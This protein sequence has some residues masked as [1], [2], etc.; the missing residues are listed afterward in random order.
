[1]TAELRRSLRLTDGVAMIVGII[2]GAGIFRTP[3]VVAA[4]LGR[5][6]L[7]FVAWVLGGV[8]ALAGA[9]IFAE[10]G[11]RHP[12]A[13]GKYVYVREAFGPRAGFVVGIVEVGI[14][15]AVIAALAVSAGEYA[16]RLVGWG[17][18]AGRLAAVGAVVL[19]TAINLAG[20]T[21]G[22]VLQNVVTAGKVIALAGVIVL[23]FAGGGASGWPAGSSGALPGAPEGVA[24]LAA[25]AGAS[26]AVIWTYYGYPDAAKIAEEVI[27]PSRTLPRI[28]LGSIAVTTALYLLLNAAFLYVLPMPVIAASDLVAGDVAVAIL[29]E[30]GGAAM[31]A[32]ALLVMLASMNGNVFVTPRVL[33]AI[34]RDGLLPGALARVNRGGSPWVAM[35]VVG[36]AALAFA[37]SGT[38]EELLGL[39]VTLVLVLDG[40]SALALVRFRRR[41]AAEPA[42]PGV[43]AAPGALHAPA[44][45]GAPFRVPLLPLVAGGFIAVYAALL[46]AAAAASPV[47]ALTA[48]AVLAIAALVGL[49]YRVSYRS[50]SRGS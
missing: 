14:Y 50:K 34:A 47:R 43:P 11:T 41:A 23:A 39:A 5:P 28:F 32:L 3:G 17:S 42:A 2:V 19:F 10:L 6:G 21:Q 18:G 27:D 15:A 7:T 40:A 49:G 4:Q 36:A 46:A 25:L 1:V 13:G 16:G 9:L 30:R 31:A 37:V 33:F 8:V 35:L 26:Q 24:V 12:R 20:V 22:R 45:P 38:F 44:A 48:A 29:G